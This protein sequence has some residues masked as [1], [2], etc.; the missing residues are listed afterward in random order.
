MWFLFAILASI[1]WGAG[2]IINQLLM[3][4]FSAIQILFF[5]SVLIVIFVLPWLIITNQ[6]KPLAIKVYQLNNASLILIGTSIYVLAAFFILSSIKGSNASIAA[7]IE[8]SYPI[9]T[10]IFAYIILR[11]VQFNI[12]ILIGTL[13]VLCGLFIINKYSN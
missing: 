3:R 6:L 2:Y 1:L 9:F 8:S 4:T 7:A 5:E 13:F 11:E 10:M 12:Y